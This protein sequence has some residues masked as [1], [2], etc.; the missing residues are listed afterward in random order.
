MVCFRRFCFVEKRSTDNVIWQIFD[1]FSHEFSLF[2]TQ[3]T[4]FRPKNSTGSKKDWIHVRKCQKLT[5]SRCRPMFSQ[6][7]KTLQNIPLW[8]WMDS[9]WGIQIR[10]A[11]MSLF[12]LLVQSVRFAFH[13]V[14][15]DGKLLSKDV[16]VLKVVFAVVKMIAVRIHHT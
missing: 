10:D 8:T 5:K 13:A 15:F 12:K 9:P 16:Q 6:R 11:V 7:N 2:S 14:N 1:I 3:L 4:L